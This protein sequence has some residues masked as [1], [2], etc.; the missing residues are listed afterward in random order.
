MVGIIYIRWFRPNDTEDPLFGAPYIGQSVRRAKLS[1]IEVA[2]QRWLQENSEG[3]CCTR[4]RLLAELLFIHGPESFEDEL[5]DSKVGTRLDVQEWAD[6]YE[7]KLI[8]QYGGPTVD[9]LSARKQTLNTTKGGKKFKYAYIDY[10]QSKLWNLFVPKMK[11]YV[12][13]YGSANVPQRFECA[14]GYKLGHQVSRI[15]SYGS[16]IEGHPCEAERKEWLESLPDWHWDGRDSRIMDRFHVFKSKLEHYID[17][18][19]NAVVLQSFVDRDGYKLGRKI[20]KIRRGEFLMADHPG[21]A[22]IVNWL[23][24][25]PGWMWHTFDSRWEEFKA[26]LIAFVNIHGHCNVAESDDKMLYTR[27]CK[28]RDRGDF[29]TG[30]GAEERRSFLSSLPGWVWNKRAEIVVQS[31]NRFK[32]EMQ[33][34]NHV[35]GHCK[36]PSKENMWLYRCVSKIRKRGQLMKRHVDSNVQREFVQGLKGWEW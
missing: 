23:N 30:V 24:S 13:E 28:I 18:Y 32:Q 31:W 5:V 1:A 34:F 11:S 16:L 22:E 7:K 9:P 26:D 27:I 4:K 12:S 15:R 25:L 21:K 29:L 36:V 6:E 10:M 3:R 14:C 2:R 20:D 17:E 33:L 35:N 8:Q 19:G